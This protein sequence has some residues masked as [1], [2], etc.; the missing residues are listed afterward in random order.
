[1]NGRDGFQKRTGVGRAA[2]NGSYKSKISDKLPPRRDFDKAGKSKKPWVKTGQIRI[3][4]ELQ[5]TDGKYRGQLIQTT[6]S[7]KMKPSPSRLRK[8]VFK[9][10][11]RRVRAGRFLDLCSG[12]GMIGLEA[13]S[14][15]AMLGTFIERSARMCTVIKKNMELCGINPGHGEVIEHEAAPF[16]KQMLKKRRRWNVVYLAPPKGDDAQD[17]L[18]FLGRGAGIAEGGALII[19]HHAETLFPPS[20]GVL[21]RA[22][23][24]TQDGTSLSFYERK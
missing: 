10:I 11:S 1:V 12:C 22:R 2:R 13:I 21:K 5:I 23:I 17:I 20:I 14:R 6:A 4:S 8:L 24:I 16:L 19:E 9:I 18:R 3:T 7:P 15:G